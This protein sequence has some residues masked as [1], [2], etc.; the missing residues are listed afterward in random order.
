LYVDYM[1]ICRK[2]TKS[3]SSNAV[4]RQ[5]VGKQTILSVT[6]AS[7][8]PHVVG[9]GLTICSNA[10]ARQPTQRVLQYLESLKNA[11][12]EQ[13]G[14]QFIFTTSGYLLLLLTTPFLFL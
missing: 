3:E 2:S 5:P 6:A 7:V 12:V 8:P 13:E 11:D 4:A 1:A 14:N 10:E 9:I